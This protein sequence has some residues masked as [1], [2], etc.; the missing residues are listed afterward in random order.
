MSKKNELKNYEYLKELHQ[1]L[2]SEMISLQDSYR[3]Q[4]L[5]VNYLRAY[6]RWKHLEEE[7]NYFVQNAY[8]VQD[9]GKPFS[10]FTL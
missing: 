3:I 1:L 5:E 2:C 9:E 8:E 6:I 4:Q 10:Y 7:Y